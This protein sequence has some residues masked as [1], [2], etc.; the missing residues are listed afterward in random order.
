MS[1]HYTKFPPDHSTCK[2][3][4]WDGAKTLIAYP[5]NDRFTKFEK[6]II[7]P[8]IENYVKIG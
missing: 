2:E 4:P 5:D 8:D 3:Y 1:K 6:V 7:D